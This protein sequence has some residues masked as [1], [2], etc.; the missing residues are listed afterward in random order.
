[1]ALADIVKVTISR[2]TT[3]VA[4]ASFGVPAVVAEFLTSK[5]TPAF[6]R[7]RFYGSTDEMLDEGWLTTDP[8]YQAAAAVLRNNPRVPGVVV[9]RKDAADA[10]W[11]AAL[12]AVRSA[13]SGWYALTIVPDSVPVATDYL[14]A[15]EWAEAQKVIFFLQATDTGVLDPASTTDIAA[16]LKALGYGR[17]VVLYHAAANEA[18]RADATWV[19]EGLPFGPGTSTWAFKQLVGVTPDTFTPGERNAALG[20]NANIYEVVAGVPVTQFG[21]TVG[22]EF[23]DIIVCVDWL[24]SRLQENVYGLLVNARKVPY[25][26][27]GITIVAGA[28]Q[29]TLEEAAR[30][31]ILQLDSI[32]LSVPTYAEIPQADRLARNLPDITF[33]AL[34]VGAVHTVEIRGV[35]SV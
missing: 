14:A 28:V 34:L 25:D 12:A 3:A 2:E 27:G 4:R 7:A 18:Q 30:A 9:G 1:M 6:G 31:G 22:G 26:D 10:S 32:V 16:A 35:V 19:G 5:T 11:A 23:V 21:K 8:V 20:K 29:A 13:N 17:T 24:E 15:A 33:T